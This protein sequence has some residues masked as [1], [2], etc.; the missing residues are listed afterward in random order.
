MKKGLFPGTFDPP[1]FGHLDLIQRSVKVCDK[2]Y[3][4][5]ADNI[6]KNHKESFLTTAEKEKILKEILQK[7]PQVEVVSFSGLVV[8]FA[9]KEGVNFLIRGLR[10]FS[11]FEYEYRMALANRTLSG[12]D[13]I[14][15][16]ADERKAHISSSLIRELVH[17]GGK[18]DE[19]VP[20]EVVLAIEK[21]GLMRA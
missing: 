21:K 17:F 20:K 1:T 11:D 2:L 16:M 19:F 14:F 4:G 7:F 12:I 15:F 13:T 6:S 3:V 5:I 8:D 18:I 9:K 10:A